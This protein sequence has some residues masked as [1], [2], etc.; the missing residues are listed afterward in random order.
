MKWGRYD[1]VKR[2]FVAYRSPFFVPY[3]GDST[4]SC[5]LD[6]YRTLT[7]KDPPRYTSR[8]STDRQMVS[9]LRKDGIKVIPLTVCRV[10]NR[11][12]LS[13][14]ILE[15]HVVLISQMFKKNE[16]SWCVLYDGRIY[17]NC[18]DETDSFRMLEFINRPILSAYILWRKK[19]AVK[20]RNKKCMVLKITPPWYGSFSSTNPYYCK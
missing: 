12:I 7:W 20:P 15:T 10:T 11:E 5:G 3:T 6:A 16:G 17:H 18:S 9:A 8:L 2:N 4:Y 13:N 14:L 19:W 1:N